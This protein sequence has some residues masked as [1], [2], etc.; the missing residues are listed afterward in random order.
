VSDRL[1]TAREV[2]ELL[3]VTPA[4]VLRWTRNGDLPAVRLPSGA[5]RYRPAELEVWLSERATPNRGVLT[6]AAG[7]A[8][9]GRYRGQC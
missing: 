7:A 3:D 1:L 4:T 6:A 9:A 2:S 8:Q 5:I